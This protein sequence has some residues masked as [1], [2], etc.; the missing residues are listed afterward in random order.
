MPWRLLK[1]EKDANDYYHVDLVQD[2]SYCASYA[3]LSYTWGGDQ[4]HKTTKVKIALQ[5]AGMLSLGWN[6]LP[7]TIQDAVKVT[8]TLG[9]SF[10]WIDSLRIVQDDEADKVMQLAQMA[11]IYKTSMITLVASRATRVSESFL[12]DIHVNK[13]LAVQ[14]PFKCP[15]DEY[16]TALLTCV[17]KSKDPEP[18]DYRAWCFQEVYLEL[19]CL[20]VTSFGRGVC[21]LN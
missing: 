6:E 18:L 3:T 7:K 11:R 1:A 21:A 20:E 8:V 17:T 12:H 9:L 19:C 13:S 2:L 16:G 4:P 5:S 14:L 15:S 10:L